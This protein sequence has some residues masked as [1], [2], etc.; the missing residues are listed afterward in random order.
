MD[1]GEV[2][3]VLVGA[4][5]DRAVLIAARLSNLQGG[6]CAEECSMLQRRLD[7]RHA[8]QGQRDIGIYVV[9]SAN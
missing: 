8:L 5:E 4:E 7:Q 2:S 9:F 6:E 3:S 1:I